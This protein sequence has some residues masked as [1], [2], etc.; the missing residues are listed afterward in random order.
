MTLYMSLMTNNFIYFIFLALFAVFLPGV[1]Y[2]QNS[3]NPDHELIFELRSPVEGSY[4]IWDAVYGAQDEQELFLSGLV[5]ESAN[6]LVVGERFGAAEGPRELVLAEFDRRGRV[7]KEQAQP[8][9]DLQQVLKIL[10]VP[11]GYAVVANKAEKTRRSI[12][13]GFF[14]AEWKFL[15]EQ[16]IRGARGDM[17]AQDMISSRDGKGFILAALAEKESVAGVSHA[18]IYR[19]DQ[20]GRVLASRAYMP[21]VE[22]SIL[23]LD[24]Q[25]KDRYVATGLIA[26]EDGR[27]TGWVMVLDREMNIVWQR[28]YPR[29]RAAM[30]NAAQD[31]QSNYI[32]VAGD[33][34][35]LGEGDTSGWVMMIDNT[36]GEIGWQRYFRSSSVYHMR[37]MMA[38]PG[39]VISVMLQAQPSIIP[40]KEEKTAEQK[41]RENYVRLLTLDPRGGILASDE[42]FSG[43][44]AFAWQMI[45]GQ[46]GERILIGASKMIYRIEGKPGEEP[47]IKRSQD[48]WLVA[49][50]EPEPYDDPCVAQ[51]FVSQP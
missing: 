49:A 40:S 33:A 51:S 22:N 29:G 47:V 12:W 30:L 43:E 34:S 1:L 36:T 14:N 24:P 31:F 15:E 6:T 32:V 27:K 45:E 37:D 7:V 4:N 28:Q 42:Y 35:P 38:G 5:L 8:V 11:G 18:V 2:A 10:S 3:C 17:T 25:G 9:K 20:K 44:D 26:A 48:G 13:L 46:L 50:T 23:G 16:S 39:G 21:G 41:A 19:L